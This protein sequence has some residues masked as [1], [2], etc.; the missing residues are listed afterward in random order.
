M[1]WL[2]SAMG[3]APE[4][5]AQVPQEEEQEE[6]AAPGAA[7]GEA[8]E[9]GEEE[10]AEPGEAAAEGEEPSEEP[11][12]E[13]EEEEAEEEGEEE[14]EPEVRQPVHARAAQP[15]L[16]P[17]CRR[18]RRTPKTL[19]AHAKRESTPVRSSGR[20]RPRWRPTLA[21]WGMSSLWTWT[22]P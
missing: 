21:C 14:G 4:P 15:P 13:G 9:E 6:E 2:Y 12:G 1:S 5:V 18:T 22:R 16:N 17:L 19:H 8:E 10:A 11:V 3:Y 20:R 7:E